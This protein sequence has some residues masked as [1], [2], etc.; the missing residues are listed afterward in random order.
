VLDYLVE[1]ELITETDFNDKLRDQ[2][3]LELKRLEFQ[4]GEHERKSNQA[5]GT[6]TERKRTRNTAKSA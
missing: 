6:G 3:L 1:E 2:Q 5:K 4:K